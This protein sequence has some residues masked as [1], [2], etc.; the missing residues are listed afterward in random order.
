MKFSIFIMCFFYKYC[1]S[2]S[3]YFKH[4]HI[5]AI[6]AGGIAGSDPQEMRMK[7][8]CSL[9]LSTWMRLQEV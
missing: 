7:T 8:Q 4:I 2:L 1:K 3:Y 9:T 6:L 5:V